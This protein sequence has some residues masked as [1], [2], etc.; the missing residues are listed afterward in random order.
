MKRNVVKCPVCGFSNHIKKGY[1]KA[2][3]SNFGKILVK[4]PYI[5]FN[6]NQTLRI[7]NQS[8][9]RYGYSEA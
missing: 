2:C 4:K 8:F 5:F 7:S 1:H 3:K 9:V 6:V